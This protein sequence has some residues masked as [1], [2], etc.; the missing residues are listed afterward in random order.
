MLALRFVPQSGF[1]DSREVLGVDVALGQLEV[2]AVDA[3]RYV[4]CG[5]GHMPMAAAFHA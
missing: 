2:T 4:A 5:L 3:L 1:G